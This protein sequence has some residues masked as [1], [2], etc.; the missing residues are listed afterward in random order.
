MAKHDIRIR[1]AGTGL[2]FL[3]GIL[4]PLAF[5]GV[6][7]LV[8]SV[9]LKVTPSDHIP[10]FP[11]YL[12]GFLPWMLFSETLIASTSAL[13]DKPYLVKKM[14]FPLGIL[15]FVSLA[16]ALVNH[17]IMFV[18][19]LLVLWYYGFAPSIYWLQLPVVFI[20][21]C[22]FSIAASILISTLNVFVRDLGQAL[23]IALN[24]AFWATPIV[25]STDKLPAQ[26]QPLA[27][28][29]PAVFLIEG[30]RSCLVY[31]RPLWENQAALTSF[32]VCTTVLLGLGL[33]TFK[34]LRPHFADVI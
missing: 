19:T 28:L 29:N 18:I 27:A 15:P 12:T 20:C 26:L 4:H 1:Y 7:W 2:G 24:I 8:F 13:V 14:P 25:W 21:V 33:F 17:L 3:W 31:N 30:Y 9:G 6:F 16:S 5:V 22:V 32:L 11:F 34:R 10:F 23:P